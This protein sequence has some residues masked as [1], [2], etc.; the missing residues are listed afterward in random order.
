MSAT[1]SAGDLPKLKSKRGSWRQ[2]LSGLL[3]VV[4]FYLL[5]RWTVF[6]A[7]VIPSGS[8]LPTLLV[9]DYIFVDKFHYG[10]RLPFTSVWIAHFAAPRRSE[11]VVFRSLEDPNRYLIKRIVAV[12][13]DELEYTAAGELKVNGVVVA[14]HVVTA[15]PKKGEWPEECLS[16]TCVLER[17]DLRLETV[18]EKSYFTWLR[19]N[20]PHVGFGPE[21][22]PDKQIFVMG[23]NRDNSYD[24][25]FWG[26]M[27]AKNLLGRAVMIWLSCGAAL[28]GSNTICDL[29]QV[30]AERLFKRIR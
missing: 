11:V 25:R 22:V 9:R 13:G 27:P 14:S 7:F 30:R 19:R 17:Y 1:L 8:M 10:L 16:A 24:S 26:Y 6:E 29:S 5:L 12:A 20:H 21:V 15:T 18:G 3:L 2:A 4:L 23:D 28:E